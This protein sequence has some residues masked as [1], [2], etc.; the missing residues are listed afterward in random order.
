M[1]VR[2]PV[3]EF[4]FSS[5]FDVPLPII[6]SLSLVWQLP[7]LVFCIMLSSTFFFIKG[8][9]SLSRSPSPRLDGG[10]STPGLTTPYESLSRQPSPSNF[11]NGSGQGVTWASAQ[12]KSV[13]VISYPSMSPQQENTNIFRRGLRKLSVSLPQF[14]NGRKSS[15]QE[16]V[17]ARGQILLQPGSWCSYAKTVG[18]RL[19]RLRLQSSIVLGVMVMVLLFYVT[20]E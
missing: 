9:M 17:D 13:K 12:M 16:K 8:T 18:R 11:A 20:R 14:A 6:V 2:L 10:W 7:F 1:H 19:W 5:N 15:K 3:I 4:R